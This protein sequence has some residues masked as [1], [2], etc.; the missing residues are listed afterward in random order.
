MGLKRE[1]GLLSD[2]NF[3][4]VLYAGQVIR[5]RKSTR[6]GVLVVTRSRQK[7]FGVFC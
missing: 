3:T 5:G 1:R 4:A 6:D 7:K 2:D